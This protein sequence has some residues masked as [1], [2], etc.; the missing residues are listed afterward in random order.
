[1]KR[2]CI[3][4][5]SVII[6]LILSSCATDQNTGYT[7]REIS[8]F[9]GKTICH[10]EPVFL[11]KILG[12]EEETEI[13]EKNLYIG[14]IEYSGGVIT[15]AEKGMMIQ[16][17]YVEFDRQERYMARAR[18]FLEKHLLTAAEKQGYNL[19]FLGT[20]DLQEGLK[21]AGQYGDIT[22]S[23]DYREHKNDG[24]DNINLPWYQLSVNSLSPEVSSFFSESTGAEYLLVPVIEHYYSHSAGWFNDQWAGCGAGIRITYHILVFDLS[25]GKKVFHFSDTEKYLEGYSSRISEFLLMQQFTKIEDRILKTILK[26]IPRG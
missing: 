18:Q 8:S 11:H 5:I 21:N 2:Y 13:S 19:V 20:E 25:N 24:K 26:K 4:G 6:L 14:N 10:I 23:I 9:S 16:T 15:N 3:F 7:A 1:M 22:F 17:K 12:I